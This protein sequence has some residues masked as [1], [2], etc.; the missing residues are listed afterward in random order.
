MMN[1]E[2]FIFEDLHVY[3]KAL[4]FVDLVYGISLRFPKSESF[5][6]QD[7]FRRAAISI[8]LNIA[9]GSGGSKLE[10]GRFI[11]ISIRSVRECV[12]IGEIAS[13]QRFISNEDRSRIRKDCAELSRMLNGLLKAIQTKTASQKR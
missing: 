1:E 2:K 7:Q 9:E 3:R 10:F 5:G 13:R 12:A 11:K 6:L 4:D 8:C